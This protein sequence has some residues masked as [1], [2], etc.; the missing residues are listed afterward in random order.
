MSDRCLR[1]C[2]S[3]SLK[4]SNILAVHE[5]RS[6]VLQDQNISRYTQ[7]D[8]SRIKNEDWW[9]NAFLH[10]VN[11]DVDIA[12]AVLLECLKWRN[13]FDVE[14]ISLLSMKPLLDRKLIYLHGKDLKSR[15]ILWIK[16]NEYRNGDIGFEKLFVFWMER[17][18]FESKGAPLTIFMDM[19][20][21]GLKNMSFDVMK[22]LIH[23]T[24]YY[25]PNSTDCIL[26]FENPSILNASWKVINSWL[27]HN[28]ELTFVSKDSVSHYVGKDNL[29]LQHGG[30]DSFVFTMEELANC[31]PPLPPQKFKLQT[32]HSID[33]NANENFS[34]GMTDF[35]SKRNVK[36]EDDDASRKMPLLVTRKSSR[37]PGKRSSMPNVLKPLIER[38]VNAKEDEFMRNSFM[39]ITPLEHLS[40]DKVDGESDFVDIIFIKNTSMKNVLFKFKTTSPEKF[41]VRPSTGVIPTGSTETIRVYLQHEYRHSWIK[42]KFLLLAAET[43]SSDIENFSEIYKKSSS[44][45]KYEHKLKCKMSE[46]VLIDLP[47]ERKS[48][49][50]T[51]EDTTTTKLKI[52]ELGS[53]QRLITIMI[54][55]LFLIQILTILYA[56]RNHRKMSKRGR[57]GASGAKFRISLGLPVGA[58]M[59]CADNTGA[60][61]L[62]VISVY[63]IRGRLNRLPSAGVGD[64]F[65]CSVKKGKP[66]LRKKVLQGVVIRQ[67]KQ[68]RRKDGTFIYFEDNAGVIVNN[69]G[70]MKGSAITGPVAKECADLWPRIAANAG[71]IA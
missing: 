29:M 35:P 27:E 32:M 9:L 51:G 37:G 1:R 26:I 58:V 34:N 16:F 17:H 48:S 56:N 57:G 47:E 43:S 6:R 49:F 65:V 11:H 67:R 54:I 19:T 42:E 31:L 36:F 12:Y 28:R 53:Y 24:R 68:F 62:F 21:T 50:L 14:H 40:L 23:T 63:G 33:D 30:L 52:A 2:S 41:R 5:L 59:N 66:E 25:Y 10:S 8:I 46:N 38:R 70:E 64:M 7:D 61:N 4:P 13:N 22:F 55:I 15:P 39:C 60:K 69:K 45:N 20:S 44:N 3:T 18:Y 71:S